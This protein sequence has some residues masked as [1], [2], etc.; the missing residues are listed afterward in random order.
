MIVPCVFYLLVVL[1][2]ITDSVQALN[3]VDKC[4]SN[5]T[6][7]EKASKR[8]GCGSD[9]YGN[10]QYICVPNVNMTNL[11]EFCFN[12]LMG[13]QEKGFCLR[14]SGERLVPESCESFSTGCPEDHYPKTEIYKYPACQT[15]NPLDIINGSKNSKEHFIL[16]AGIIFAA[17]FV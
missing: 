1:V 4:P 9:K 8:L 15:I 6:E 11:V 14:A 17:I 10:N 3:F 7:K 12:G 2:S 13:T 5:L 16:V